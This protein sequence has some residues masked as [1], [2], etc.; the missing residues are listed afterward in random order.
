MKLIT[1]KP[2]R[3]GAALVLA[4]VVLVLGGGPAL[5]AD[6]VTISNTETVQAHLD[7]DGK[8][9][10]AR[11]YEQIALQGKGTVTIKNPV[12]TDKLRNLDGFRDFTVKDGN[13]VSTQKVNGD[14]RLRAVSD[15]DRKLPLQVTVTYKLDGESVKAGDVVGRSG[16]LE[17]HYRVTN[18][19]G[20]DT[21]VTFDDGTG[22]KVTQTQKV[23]IPMVG[24]LTTVLPPS[25][26][27]VASD[28]ANM[29]GDG[30]G[31]TKMSFTMTLFA[32]VAGPTSEFGY[33]ATITDG[34]IPNAAISALPVSPLDSPSFKGAAASYKGGADTGVQLTAGATEIDANVLRLRDGAQSLIAGLI[35]LRDGAQKLNAGLAHEAAPGAN[36]LAQGASQLRDGAG[37]LAAGA[38]DAEAGSRQLDA[39]SGK[40]TAG[41]GKLDAGAVRLGSAFTNPSRGPDLTSGSAALA[42]GVSK[43][44]SGL[45]RLSGVKGLPKA[46]IGLQALHTGLDHRVGASGAGDP[47]GL[48]QGLQQI[49]G[50]LSNPACS[51]GDPTNAKNPCGVKQGLASV[52]LGVSNPGCSLADPSNA[53]NPCG[54]K[55]VVDYV[56]GKLTTASA[57]GGDIATLGSAVIGAYRQSTYVDAASA[58]KQCP[59]SSAVPV[60]PVV[61]PSSL[62]AL[63]LP[64]TGVCVL[65]SSA[66]YGLLL[67]SGVLSNSDPGGLKAQT[68]AAGGALV[69][70]GSGVDGRLLPGLASLT[71]GVD[72]LA[73]GSVSAQDGVAKKILPG[74]NLLVAGVTDAVTGSQQLSTGALA[75]TAGSGALA[76]GISKAG[77]GAGQLRAGTRELAAGAHKL[78]SGAGQLYVGLGKI[79]GG[80]TALSGGTVALSD[81]AKKLASG[82]GE[83]ATGS[84]KLAAGLVT[85]AD[86]GKALPAGASRLS[87]EG[88][89]KLVAAGKSTASDYGLKYAVIV[90]GAERAKT[91]GMAYGAPGNAAGATAYSLEISGANGDGGQSMGRGAGALAL[92]GSGAGLLLFRRRVV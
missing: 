65:L 78:Q 1:S 86:G 34:V 87:A 5:A 91:E 29:A 72:R 25:F 9:H 15:F 61:P 30:H 92:F 74:V 42:G 7:A 11:V 26:V 18:V 37:K 6:S 32:P 58:V 73:A 23:V 85:A 41:A 59:T 53:K 45:A 17:V 24:S 62:V 50:G 79:S 47:G 28:E 48:L 22:K 46:L 77:A 35:Q 20:K 21:S 89:S 75:A 63:G 36:K 54:I 80:A 84:G 49:S 4:P 64:S 81:G 83:A 82:L 90:A 57:A 12:S 52:G 31:Q 60:P 44:S 66:A 68:S 70:T 13:I 14:Q 43:I 51:P 16:R 76:A 56:G 10:D 19:T 71:S 8:V 55:Q 2:A 38:G 27:D 69:L 39:G 88:T 40:L 67:P 33:T 3:F